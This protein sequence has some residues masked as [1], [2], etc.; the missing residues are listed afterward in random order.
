IPLDGSG[1]R[2]TA[3]HPDGEHLVIAYKTL[4]ALMYVTVHIVNAPKQKVVRTLRIPSPGLANKLFRSES[5]HSDG[6]DKIT[7]D[8]ASRWLLAASKNGK[9]YRWD[10]SN[11][12]EAPMV[13]ETGYPYVSKVLPSSKRQCLF[14]F[15]A[16]SESVRKWDLTTGRVAG[17]LSFDSAIK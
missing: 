4:H 10:W 14:A 12:D 7:F 17:E 15:C 3:A 9:I 11:L 16:Q 8:Q 2:A 13:I 5:M 1:V 6:I